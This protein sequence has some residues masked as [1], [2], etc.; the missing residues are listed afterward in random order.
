MSTPVSEN[1]QGGQTPETPVPVEGGATEVIVAEPVEG[2]AIEGG[3]KLTKAERSAIAKRSWRKR[4]GMKRSYHSK[5][6]RGK[7]IYQRTPRGRHYMRT[8]GKHREFGCPEGKVPHRSKKTH[9]ASCV[10]KFSKALPKMERSCRHGKHRNSKGRCV[11]TKRKAS[12]SKL[13]GGAAEE[14]VQ[15]TPVA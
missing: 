1:V 4:K 13:I 5:S 2:G 9:R 6:P 8:P 7:V 14:V 10:S 12:R 15:Q 11:Q 3:K